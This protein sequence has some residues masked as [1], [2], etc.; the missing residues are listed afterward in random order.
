[1]S[2]NIIV[3]ID[4]YAGCGKSTTARRL[5][6]HLG[7]TYL[8]TG[9]MYR[10]VTLYFLDHDVNLDD[11]E[12]VRE[13]LSDIQIRFGEA[14][15]EGK[16]DTYLNGRNVEEDIRGL[17]VSSHVSPVSA[18]PAVRRFLVAQQQQIGRDRGVVAEGRDIGTHVFPDAELK[19]FMTAG[20][21]ARVARRQIEMQKK[22]QAVTAEA[23][24]ENLRE[25]DRIDTGR[26]DS[27][28]RRAHDARELDTTALTIEQ[29]VDQ[30]AGWVLAV[31]G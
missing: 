8:D 2:P 30:I 1:M 4:G 9:A 3:A 6:Q 18:V 5:A 13:A 11:A 23:L 14:T 26:E 22:G 20:M 29:Q 31:G 28:L 27:P 10:A 19:V 15:P 25:R 24:E 7:Y 16:R 12:A 17:R 21:P